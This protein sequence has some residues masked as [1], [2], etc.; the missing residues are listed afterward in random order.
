[1]APIA[2]GFQFKSIWDGLKTPKAIPPPMAGAPTATTFALAKHQAV[3]AVHVVVAKEHKSA[4]IVLLHKALQTTIFK[5]TMNLMMKLVPLYSDH[6]P[7]TEQDIIHHT[8]TKQALCLAEFE[9]L[10]NPHIDLTDEPSAELHNHSLHSIVMA[11]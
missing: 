1:M 6:L 8:I 2:L 7:S 3:W 9:F 5:H 4:A 11:Y 10:S